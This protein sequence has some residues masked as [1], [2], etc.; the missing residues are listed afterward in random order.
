MKHTANLPVLGFPWKENQDLTAHPG[1]F[2]QVFVAKWKSRFTT[3][4]YR[5]ELVVIISEISLLAGGLLFPKA[6]QDTVATACVSVCVCTALSD[7]TETST[8]PAAQVVWVLKV[9]SEGKR[10]RKSEAEWLCLSPCV[11]GLLSSS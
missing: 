2:Q 8:H 3:K 4:T 9:K 10:S 11:N 7:P 5:T 6:G 1:D